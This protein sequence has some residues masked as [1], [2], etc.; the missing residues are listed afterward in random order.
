MDQYAVFGNPIKQSKSP[1]IHGEFAK[2]TQQSLH[3]RAQLVSLEGFEHEVQEF[4]SLGGAGLNI[5]APF[6]ERAWAMADIRSE[7]AQKSGA[8]NTLYLNSLGQICGDNTDGRGLLRDLTNNHG[9]NIADKT[10]LL[11]G[12]GGAIKG[13]MSALIAQQPAS[14]TIANRTLDK[15][16]AIAKTYADTFA[17]TASPYEELPSQHYDF[18]ING[19]SSGLQGGLPPIPEGVVSAHTWC[20]DMIYGQGDTVFQQW[21]KQQGA[22]KALDGLGMLV[23]QAAES[24]KIWRHCEPRT[25]SVIAELRKIL[26]K[27]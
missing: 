25:E 22:Y 27:D 14:I 8:V 17:V 7:G 1:W 15:A 6:K 19:T 2:Q 10:V 20:Y 23:E 21:A 12:A 3:Y 4:F 5:T 18:I 24:F 26:A 16:L 9:A 13:V 11:L